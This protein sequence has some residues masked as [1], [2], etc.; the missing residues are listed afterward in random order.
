MTI[1][2]TNEQYQ[3]L[4]EL[5]F[6]GELIKTMNI[7][8]KDYKHMVNLPSTKL[9]NTILSQAKQFNS[10][11]L[12]EYHQELEGQYTLNDGDDLLEK[13]LGM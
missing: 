10:E 5:V 1:E 6:L 12:I 13:Y 9:K 8:P 4:I 3:E 2:L 11:Y 7:L